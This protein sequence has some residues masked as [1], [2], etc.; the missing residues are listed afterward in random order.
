ML[1]VLFSS[2]RAAKPPSTSTKLEGRPYLATISSKV[3]VPAFHVLR[4]S[5]NEARVLSNVE[6][7]DVSQAGR[8]SMA[9]R[10]MM[11]LNVFPIILLMIG[12]E[13]VEDVETD[14]DGA[15]AMGEGAAGDEIKAEIAE[16]REAFERNVARSF[17]LRTA[18]D[19]FD[20]FDHHV[21]GHVV[22]QNVFD[23]RVGGLADIVKVV[24]FDFDFQFWIF[25]AALADGPCDGAFTNGFCHFTVVV[26][27]HDTV[28]QTETVVLRAA[29]LDGVFFKHAQTGG[30]F[31]RVKKFRLGVAQ[32]Q[33][34]L[35]GHGGDAGEAL[36]EIQCAA[37]TGEN[38]LRLAAYDGE[39]RS[40]LAEIAFLHKWLEVQ[41]AVELMENGFD[42][43]Q[44]RADAG[45]SRDETRL[46]FKFFR[47]D[48]ERRRVAGADVF[49]E[50][51]TTDVGKDFWF[52]YGSCHGMVSGRLVVRI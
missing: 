25:F 10:Q 43:G 37:F 52:E 27:D 7:L 31:A 47:H 11:A 48:G 33:N 45:L 28:E 18:G 2:Q 49:G 40:G 50:S 38:G 30:G 42:D 24:R 23:A 9:K 3:E 22:Q 6:T 41:R 46:C 51:E 32:R 19:N 26:L 20:G 8:R 12:N 16:G 39:L 35:A 15:D 44:A 13:L 1:T 17:G 34:V 14:V 29:D 36:H 5:A 4:A 21:V